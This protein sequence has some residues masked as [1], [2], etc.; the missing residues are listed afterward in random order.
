MARSILRAVLD[1]YIKNKWRKIRGD[2]GK[3]VIKKMVKKRKQNRCSKA[4]REKE[5]LH[6]L[7]VL[8]RRL[9]FL[10]DGMIGFEANGT[11]TRARNEIERLQ[12]AHDHLEQE[13]HDLWTTPPIKK[14]RARARDGLL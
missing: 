2:A 8:D 14:Q 10:S 3:K 5:I 13:L 12:S 9:K 7:E 4:K 11:S 6:D 1:S